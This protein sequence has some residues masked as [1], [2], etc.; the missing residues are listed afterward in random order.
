M[1]GI[2][3]H[4]RKI[5]TLLIGHGFKR[6]EEILFDWVL[7]GAVMAWATVHYGQLWGPVVTF[8]TLAPLSAL[9]CWAEIMFYDWAKK[10]WLGLEMLKEFRDEEKH[11][12]WFGRMLHRITR[13]G[14]IP[15]FFVLSAHTDAFITTAYF[16]PKHRQYHG[17]TRRDWGIFWSS[18][19]VSN[20]YWTL[21]WTLIVA[22]ISWLWLNVL[23]PFLY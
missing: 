18:I 1:S 22:V 6:V 11:E 20:M 13:W 10:D 17:M 19:A 8:T 12:H 14:H 2:F 15:A 4:K 21:R 16:R 9:F 3:R 5:G 23:A 7:Y